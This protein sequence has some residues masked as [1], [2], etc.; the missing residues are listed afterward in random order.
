MSRLKGFLWL[1]VKIT[2]D[3]LA[4]FRLA[5][6]FMIER[7]GERNFPVR[8]VLLSTGQNLRFRGWR[9]VGAY[10]NDSRP[11]RLGRK[12]NAAYGLKQGP[13]FILGYDGPKGLQRKIVSSH[14]LYQF[15]IEPTDG[16]LDILCCFSSLSWLSGRLFDLA[17][18]GSGKEITD[19]TLLRCST[20]YSAYVQ[21]LAME[22]ELF[23]SREPDAQL[24]R[25]DK[26]MKGRLKAIERDRKN[27]GAITLQ[28][29][30]NYHWRRWEVE[31]F[32]I[33]L[34]LIDQTFT[35]VLGS[36]DIN[37]PANLRVMKN[38]EETIYE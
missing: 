34:E 11:L 2:G 17:G 9:H 30:K 24:F 33:Q 18:C 8:A 13:C 35:M 32:D 7:L 36:K 15:A 31:K 14:F 26:E 23:H 3:N 1:A 27:F 5:V 16:E 10:W 6:I 19:K 37:H 12:K 21:L 22:L 28:S 25:A 4:N 29:W 38:M 20:V